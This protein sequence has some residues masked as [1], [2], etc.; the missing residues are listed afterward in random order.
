MLTGRPHMIRQQTPVTRR[1]DDRSALMLNYPNL[2][3]L[4][5]LNYVQRSRS[6]CSSTSVPYMVG[7]GRIYLTCS[8]RIGHNRLRDCSPTVGRCSSAWRVVR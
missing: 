4:A 7:R 5:L 3:C 2:S 6:R 8:A 1:K